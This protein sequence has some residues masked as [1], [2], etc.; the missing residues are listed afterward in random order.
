[1]KTLAVALFLV[2]CAMSVTKQDQMKI[3]IRSKVF[4]ATLFENETTKELRKMLP[5]VIEMTDLNSNEKYFHLSTDLPTKVTKPGTIKAGDIMLFGSNS[6]VLFYESFTTSYS[7]TKIGH[8]D[9]VTGLKEAVGR[10]NVEVKFQL[11]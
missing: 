8:I 4:N 1:M 11:E 10:G 5:M 7:Y 3:T 6:L 2:I 9:D